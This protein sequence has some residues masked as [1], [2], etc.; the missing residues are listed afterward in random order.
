MSYEAE[1]IRIREFGRSIPREGYKIFDD[2]YARPHFIYHS[3]NGVKAV[4][5]DTWLTAQKRMGRESQ[6]TKYVTGFHVFTSEE[7]VRKYAGRF[8]INYLRQV[9]RVE[10]RRARRKRNSSVVLADEIRV[11]TKNWRGRLPLIAYQ[12]KES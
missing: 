6:S 9:V 2:R 11:S 1:Q 12:G 4:P 7:E 8:Q 3:L 10:Y 5:L